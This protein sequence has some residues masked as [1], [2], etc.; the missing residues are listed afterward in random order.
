MMMMMMMMI[1]QSRRVARSAAPPDPLTRAPNVRHT[2]TH[3]HTRNYCTTYSTPTTSSRRTRERTAPSSPVHAMLPWP[4]QPPD[5]FLI[6]FGFVGTGC[7]GVSESML[8][9][10]KRGGRSYR[11]LGR[12]HTT[13]TTTTTKRKRTFA[14]HPNHRF[15]HESNNSS[16]CIGL[17]CLVLSCLVFVVL[18]TIFS[19]T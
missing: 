2:H 15:G 17:D 10:C 16:H 4:L 13:T 12:S 3:T 18:V 1:E 19:I 7:D 9:V 11:L 8:P 14:S 5:C 6:F